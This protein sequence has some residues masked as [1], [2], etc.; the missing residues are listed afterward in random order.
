VNDWLKLLLEEVRRRRKEQEEQAG[1]RKTPAP[2]DR[3]T[4]RP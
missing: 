3:R 1:Q 2:G 4:K